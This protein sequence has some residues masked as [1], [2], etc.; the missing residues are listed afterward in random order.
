MYWLWEIAL[1][2]VRLLSAPNSPS[3]FECV[4][5][6][7]TLGEAKKIRDRFRRGSVVYDV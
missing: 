4:F 3:R 2:T 6:C 1:E 7:E 5:A